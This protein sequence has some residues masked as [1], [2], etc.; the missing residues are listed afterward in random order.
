MTAAGDWA[1]A[2]AEPWSWLLAATVS[3]GAMLYVLDDDR[4]L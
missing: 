2:A 3:G 1:A 4:P